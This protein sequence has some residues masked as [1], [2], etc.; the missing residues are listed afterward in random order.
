MVGVLHE[1]GIHLHLARQHGL[2]GR[3]DIVPR[4]NL[5]RARR[6]FR[7]F[8]NHAQ[9]LLPRKSLCSKGI[10]ALI[11]LALVLG[12]PFLRRLMRC[13]R[14]ARRVV[15][16]EGLVGHQRLLLAH[17]VDG[18]VGHVF[19]EVIAFFGRL[20][21]LQRRG[22][23]VDRGVILVGLAAE[24]AIEVLEAAAA[25]GPRIERPQRAG[26]PHRDLVALAELRRAVAVE[27]ERFGQRRAGVRTDR[28]VARRG[29]GEFGDGPHADGVV[30]APGQ[31]RLASG[32]AERGRVK[33]VVAQAV[34]GESLEVGRVARPAECA[35]RA[36]ARIVEQNDETLGAPAG[37][38]SGSI[39]GNFASGSLASYLTSPAL[40]RWE[41][42]AQ[43]ADACR[44]GLP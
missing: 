36:E 33:A 8:W 42:A 10:P 20:G 3:V 30:V 38:R 2:E 25:R 6:Q 16:E 14:R 43:S 15:D 13:M 18:L 17:P 19:G 26:L 37:G 21:R 7:V 39:G 28:G 27:L 23:F 4:R 35:R 32:R 12:R 9:R 41:W 44:V 5:R 24:K 1:P 34:R 40:P 29:R 11:E 31:Q 22:P